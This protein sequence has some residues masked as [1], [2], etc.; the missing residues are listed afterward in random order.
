M[1]AQA[2]ALTD[3]ASTDAASAD[4][5]AVASVITTLLD[6]GT[7]TE[8]LAALG[9]GDITSSQLL[10]AQLERIDKHNDAVNAVVGLDLERARVEAV[11][12]DEA[13]AAGTNLGLLHGLP[14]TVKDTYE[15]VGLATVAGSPELK[16]HMALA[17]ADLVAALRHAGAIV[18]GKTNVPLFAGDHQ[19][20]NAVF[21]VSNNPYDLERTPGGSSGGAA[22]S[23]A[24]GFTLAEVGSD[25]GSSVRLPAHFN[26]V[27]GLKPTHGVLSLRGHVSGPTGVLAHPDLAV[28]GPM[29]RSA[30]DLSLLLEVLVS[31]SSFD[32]IPGAAL[33]A[34]DPRPVSDLRVGVWSDD[35]VAPVASCVRDVI[36]T[37]GSKLAGAGA[38]V[39]SDARPD[40]S[41]EEL[42]KLY[43]QLLFPIIGAG[44]P[45]KSYDRLAQ[46][47]NDPDGFGFDESAGWQPD[48][49]AQEASWITL[50]HR[51][52]LKANELRA[53]AIAS[54]DQLFESV[55][56][57]I[58]PP[59]PTVAF[60]HNTD[61]PYNQRVTLIDGVERPYTELLFW[62]GIATM[63]LLPSV[64][65]PAGMV[66]GL[67]CGAQLIGK[68]WS[69]FQLLADA[70]TICDTLD[71][72]FQPPDLVAG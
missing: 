24:C 14:M 60:P 20:Y 41:S 64:V 31:E 17:D 66:D 39:L 47:A 67:P 56:L 28:A 54:W 52:W 11:A 10:E 15:T 5:A 29:A 27:F 22:A 2:T 62:A 63:P 18:F 35:D 26:G 6:S 70:A 37:L 53:K 46:F 9:R 40:L 30:P 33:P 44:F 55:D 3:A 71:L 72:R 51:D 50:A 45:A 25:I 68:R 36:E 7:V 58:A 61:L 48:R 69:D 49:S 19:T 34:A 13:R 59:A 12:A 23:L 4:A 42:H 43:L 16:D 32:G 38:R 57:M 21:G 65:I 1:T 8:A